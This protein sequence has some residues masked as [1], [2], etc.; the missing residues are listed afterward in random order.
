MIRDTLRAVLVVAAM[1]VAAAL[2]VQARYE[3][4]AIDVAHRTCLAGHQ[5]VPARQ[6]AAAVPALT[7]QPSPLRRLG[8]ATLDMADAALGIVR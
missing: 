2:L 5:W 8:R 4:A 3:L 6:P 7:E 1:A